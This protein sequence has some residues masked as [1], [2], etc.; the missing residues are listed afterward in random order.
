MTPRLFIAGIVVASLFAAACGSGEEEMPA[1]TTPGASSTPTSEPGLATGRV[2]AGQALRS[3]D[4]RLE[5]EGTG[6]TALDVTIRESKSP[7]SAPKGWQLV[8][9]VYDVAARE[10]VSGTLLT[11]LKEPFELRFTTTE[12][13]ATLMYFDGD[14]WEMVR[15]DLTNGVVEARIDHLAPYAAAKPAN[16]GARNAAATASPTRPIA[17]ARTQTASQPTGSATLNTGTPTAA[18]ARTATSVP[19]MSP[20]AVKAALESAVSK[21]KG[22]TAKVMGAAASDGTGSLTLP[23]QVAAAL[24]QAGLY[25]ETSSGLYH[26]VNEAFTA[27]AP[28]GSFTLL[29]E[30]KIEFPSSSSRAQELLAG[31]FPGA[32]GVAYVAI[33][34]GPA[35][36]TY[37]GANGSAF[38]VLGFVQQD[39]VPLAFLGTGSGGFVSVA[40]SLK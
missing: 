5:V 26:G 40:V 34:S 16:A 19:T 20:E 14:S 17:T 22:G 21:Y 37:Q 23:P 6:R 28:T 36:Y 2:L 39:G 25:G 32:A 33:Q 8:T 4:G 12:S 31:Y 35:T 1:S 29:V 30:P 3:A 27:S 24:V 7:P 15:S 9:P 18:P 38:F 13:L 10:P 11:Q